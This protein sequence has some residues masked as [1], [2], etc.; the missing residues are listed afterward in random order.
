MSITVPLF[1]GLSGLAPSE[2]AAD[3]TFDLTWSGTPYGDS[4]KATGTVTMDLSL[5]DNPGLTYSN[6]IAFIIDFSI[7]VTGASSGNGTF[8]LSDFGYLRLDTNGGTLDFSEQLV[9]QATA[10]SPWGTTNT[11]TSGDFNLFASGNDLSAPYGVYPFSFKTDGGGGDE[12]FLTRFAPASVP[13]PSTLVLGGIAGLAGL[14]LVW[15]RR[16]A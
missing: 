13:E 1:L 16:T 14:G 10:G 7:T 12:L 8:D 5:I 2:G 11:G 9:G 4:A 15:R 3:A 6:Q